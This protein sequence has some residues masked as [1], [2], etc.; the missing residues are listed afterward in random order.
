MHKDKN[1]NVKNDVAS[2]LQS[3]LAVFIAL[4][5]VPLTANAGLVAYDYAG[6][7][8]GGVWTISGTF[9]LDEADVIA[10]DNLINNIVSWEF[11]WTNGVEIIRTSSDDGSTL[12]PDGSPQMNF[13]FEVDGNNEVLRVALESRPADGS[14]FPLFGF[15]FDGSTWNASTSPVDCCVQGSGSFTA[16]RTLVESVSIEIRPGS[17]DNCGGVIPVAILG[18]NKLNVAQID[19]ATLSFSGLGIRTKGNGT[20]LC[21]IEDVNADGFDDYVCKFENGETDGMVSGALLDGTAIE[22]SDSFCVAH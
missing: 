21:G 3:K 4:F 22:G 13:Y 11:S 12:G 1:K 15:E 19:P 16:P 17:D 14:R 20:A 9:V 18:S 2:I 5:L 6:E 8:Y 7:G 10:G